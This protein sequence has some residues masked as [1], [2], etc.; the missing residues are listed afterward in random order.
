MVLVNGILQEH[1]IHF[2]VLIYFCF[3][4]R[5]KDIRTVD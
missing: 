4:G 2:F 1:G 5:K 3:K